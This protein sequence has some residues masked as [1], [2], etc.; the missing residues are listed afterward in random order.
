MVTF[1]A[2]TWRALARCFASSLTPNEFAHRC[3]VS[4]SACHNSPSAPC[5]VTLPAVA[6]APPPPPPRHT[7]ARTHARTHTHMHARTQTHRHTDACQIHNAAAKQ[8]LQS[9]AGV[10][11][12]T[13][14]APHSL[15][16]FPPLDAFVHPARRPHARTRAGQ[17]M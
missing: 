11:I 16:P 4:A 15:P 2:H 13:A 10:Y 9:A 14:P 1:L 5:P 7:Y 17:E 6:A 3:N 8:L 12:I